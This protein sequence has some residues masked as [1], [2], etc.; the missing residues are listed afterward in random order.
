[1]NKEYVAI[2]FK[3]RASGL[4][5]KTMHVVKCTIAVQVLQ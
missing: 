3:Q 4:V 1:M 5:V 2:G